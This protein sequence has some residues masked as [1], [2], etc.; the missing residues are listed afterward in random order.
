MQVCVRGKDLKSIL[1]VES[2]LI[3]AVLKFLAYKVK[4]DFKQGIHFCLC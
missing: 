1:K 4:S 3:L 2:K